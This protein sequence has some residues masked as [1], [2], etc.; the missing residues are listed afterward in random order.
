[1]AFLSLEMRG[2][3]KWGTGHQNDDKTVMAV[4]QYNTTGC[5]ISALFQY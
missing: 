5:D 1:M 2:G 4:S 3:E